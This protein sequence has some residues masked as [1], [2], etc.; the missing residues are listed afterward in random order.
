M[1]S[2][3]ELHQQLIKKERTAVEIAQE[4]LDH[5][6]QLEPKLKSFL[7]VTPEK[8]LQQAREVDAKIAQGEEIGPL[9]GIPIAIKD[10]MCTEGIR[11][12]CGSRILENFIPPYESTVTTKLADAG[13]V[14]V[15]KTNMD[16]FA[17]GSSTENSAYQLT[18]NPWDLERVPG[19]SSGGSAAAVAAGECV[20][21]LGSDT[22]GSIRQP[23]SFCG[24]I[25][26][27]PTYGLVSRYGLV[28]YASSLDQ[29]GPFGRS[30]EDTAILL[31]AIA[32]YDPKDS[33][34][35]NVPIP[36]YAKS[37]KPNLKA[38]GQLRIGVIKET[39]GEGLDPTVEAAVTTAVELLQ[40]LGAE[41]S[42]VS[43]P[44]FRYGL[45]TYYI[46]APSEAS[47]NLARY[48]GVKY[49]FRSEDADNLLEMYGKTRAQGFGTEVKRRIMV[50]TYALSAGYYDAYY[51][52]AQKV[53]TLIKEDF[54]RAF[55]QVDVLVC[56]TAPTTAFKAG[57]KT[58]DPLS[59]YLGDLMTI[60]VNLA[61]LP[62]MS[63]PCGYD[64]KG[65]PIGLQLIGRVL[66]ESRLLEVAY[67]YEQA[68]QWNL[69]FPKLA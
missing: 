67:A 49:G 22:G 15:G 42:V 17:M 62:G 34:S 18:R 16:E 9:A 24:V 4:A 21:A 14:L 23:A 31:S 2:I 33:T 46:I 28:A 11:T 38:R 56:P 59:M 40:E 41:I 13:A 57:E 63:I 69:R 45:P 29:I 50:G 1:A 37:L 47:A 3:R 51:L 44:R 39:F 61:G 43:C 66:Q 48:D 12:T 5:I 30:V 68:T 32:G 25:G 36:D 55:A 54:D 65:L 8:A 26:L 7:T 35:L 60:P 19:G 6:S 58:E 20:V 27:K 64:E 53:R 10:N 52:K